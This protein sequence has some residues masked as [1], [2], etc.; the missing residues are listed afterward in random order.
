MIVGLVGK[1]K[2]GLIGY[3]HTPPFKS[4]H[5]ENFYKEAPTELGVGLNLKLHPNNLATWLAE[6]FVPFAV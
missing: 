2:H 1:P 3:Q 5:G 6:K 4:G